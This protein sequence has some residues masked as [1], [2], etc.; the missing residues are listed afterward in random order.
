MMKIVR[1]E[2][3]IDGNLVLENDLV[4]IAQ[5]ITISDSWSTNGYSLLL[6]CEELEIKSAGLIIDSS[7]ID[8][9]NITNRH[10]VNGKHAGGRGKNGG[11]GT[12]G[13]SGAHAGHI[14]IWAE[15]ITGPALKIH[16][17]GADGGNGGDGGNGSK[18]VDLHNSYGGTCAY[19]ENCS[20][21]YKGGSGGDS[22]LPGKGAD[23]SN[24]GDIFIRT[25]VGSSVNESHLY[26]VAGEKGT[27]GLPGTAGEGGKG[28]RYMV[29][30][31]G[32]IEL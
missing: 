17:N 23:G 11:I 30:K 22:G 2:Y 8:R 1:K 16:A 24:G 26:N 15:V 5:T 28:M 18:G 4:I 14:K 12:D 3:R 31:P 32:N 25:L 10:G 27:N 19:H 13:K 7:S 6:F 21:F 9:Q 29:L 20:Q